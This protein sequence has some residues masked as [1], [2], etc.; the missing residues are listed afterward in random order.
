MNK[1]HKVKFI[2]GVDANQMLVKKLVYNFLR[3]GKITTT[4]Q[5]AK[6]VKSEVDSFVH[7][8]KADKREVRTKLASFQKE[9]IQEIIDGIK[10]MED[11]HGGYIRIIK[12]EDRLGDGAKMTKVEWATPYNIVKAEEITTNAK[13][14]L[15]PSVSDVKEAEIVKS[16]DVET[17]LIAPVRDK[18]IKRNKKNY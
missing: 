14:E 4:T 12:L 2:K 3:D 6:V 18:K 1:A 13:S 10:S 15:T 16:S 9:K 7:K 17:R 8:V 5:K 11:R